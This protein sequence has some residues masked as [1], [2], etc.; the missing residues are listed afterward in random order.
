MVR[1][2]RLFLA[3][4]LACL[5]VSLMACGGGGGSSNNPPPAS[6]DGGSG[7]GNDLNPGI[8]GKFFF[9]SESQAWLMD[10]NSGQYTLIPNTNWEDQND[11]FLGVAQY[12]AKS[13]SS[14]QQFLLTANACADSTVN[15][16]NDSCIISQSVAGDYTND[17]RLEFRVHGP[18]IPSRDG[19]YFAV[20]RDLDDDWL[21]IYDLGGNFVSNIRTGKAPFDWLPDGSLV[22]VHEGR[23]FAFTQVLDTSSDFAW[24]LPTGFDSGE[25]AR[26]EVSPDGQYVAFTH[27]SD[28]TLVSEDSTLWLLNVADGGIR[29]LARVDN[30]GAEDAFHDFAWSPDGSMIAVLEGGVTGSGV[31]NPGLPAAMYVIPTNAQQSVVVSPDPELRSPEVIALTRYLYED[32]PIADNLVTDGFPDWD[33]DWLAE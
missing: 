8:S 20:F 15:I 9:L 28:G 32:R 25:I 1:G 11:R 22:Y 17:V 27:R 7:G 30:G 6:D 31:S 13:F 2:T 19:G 18:A 21:A 12:S 14:G 23:T 4:V 33:F 5:F 16:T 29:R 26:L 3:F 10:I 24:A